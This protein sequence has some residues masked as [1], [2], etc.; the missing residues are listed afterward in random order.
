MSVVDELISRVAASG[1][2][3]QGRL[4]ALRTGFETEILRPEAVAI[5]RRVTHDLIASGQASRALKAG[6][7]MPRF[8]L[9]NLDGKLVT[10]EE[11][12]ARGALVLTFYW[13]LWCPYCAVDLAVF[14]AVRPEFERRSA[15]LIAVSQQVITDGSNCPVAI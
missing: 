14:E 1:L 2:S 8:A 7:Q 5:M 4:E 10:S 9:P 6:D 11:L 3:L 13:G 12:L 15:S